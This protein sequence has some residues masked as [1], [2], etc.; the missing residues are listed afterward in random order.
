MSEQPN[1]QSEQVVPSSYVDYPARL[2]G[3]KQARYEARPAEPD[4]DASGDTLP[5]TEPDGQEQ[6]AAPS[7]YPGGTRQ[8]SQEDASSYSARSRRPRAALGHFQGQAYEEQDQ[9][10]QQ[11]SAQG[12][13]DQAIENATKIGLWGSPQSGKTTFLA[14]LRHAVGVPENE[15]GDWTITALSAESSDLMVEFTRALNRG[16]FPSATAPGTATS[17]RWLFTGDIRKSKF[18]GRGERMRKA[19]GHRRIESSFILDLIDVSG[20]AFSDN[21]ESPGFSPDVSELALNHLLDSKG[22][23]YLFDPMRERKHG[24]ALESV[25]KTIVE[26]KRKY[27][28]RTKKG[29]KLPHQ[30]SVCVTK[31]DHADVFQEAR[32]GGLV[33]DGPDGVPRVRD[34]HAKEFFENLC[35]GG[36]WRQKRNEHDDRSAEMVMA[37][38]QNA[39]EADNIKYFVTSSIGFHKK[40]DSAS[41]TREFDAGDFSNFHETSGG[42]GG[43]RGPIHPINVLEPLISL[44]QR[45]TGRA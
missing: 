11:S 21:P 26:L 13:S 2:R 18:V 32:R 33:Y 12:V 34:E 17:L 22:L 36:F 28:E 42:V 43:I 35:T 38:L 7:G 27:Y 37:E 40:P 1:N 29:G 3:D 44:Q 45:M 14:A 10:Q 41:G 25:N 15:Y 19:F 30:L 5:E 9:R 23:I 20:V 6:Q 39:F 8:G 24:D 16:Q 4:A 31:F